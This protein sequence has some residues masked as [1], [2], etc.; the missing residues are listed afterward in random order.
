MFD[1]MTIQEVIDAYENEGKVAIINDGKLI[2][3]VKEE[4]EGN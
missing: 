3:M 1:T 4:K 2:A